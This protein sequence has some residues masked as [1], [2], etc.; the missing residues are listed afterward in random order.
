MRKETK[1]W[2]RLSAQEGYL[3]AVFQGDP[4]KVQVKP[5]HQTL[6][7]P[8]PEVIQ[9]K[10]RQTMTQS[11]S[12]VWEPLK[13]TVEG[14]RWISTTSS[15]GAMAVYKLGTGWRQKPQSKVSSMFQEVPADYWSAY[16]LACLAGA[17]EGDFSA[18][19]LSAVQVPHG[20]AVCCGKR[21]RKVFIP[22]LTHYL[23]IFTMNL[24]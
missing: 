14:E 11:L 1:G 24:A 18:G 15:N 12:C 21:A 22:D 20:E 16:G 2:H 6:A 4:T 9:W 13:R 10:N 17:G 7:K 3:L 19:T 23:R 5:H 8:F